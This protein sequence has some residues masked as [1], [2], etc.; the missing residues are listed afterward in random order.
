MRVDGKVQQLKKDNQLLT[1]RVTCVLDRQ[2]KAIT[3]MSSDAGSIQLIMARRSVS[4]IVALELAN[5]NAKAIVYMLCPR[6]VQEVSLGFML[7]LKA[8]IQGLFEGTYKHTGYYRL[9]CGI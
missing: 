7:K 3:R 6:G 1:V 2:E 4:R 5:R 8:P 9:E